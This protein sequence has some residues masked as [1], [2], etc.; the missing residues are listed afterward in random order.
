MSEMAE[1][2]TVDS[3]STGE[4]A[5]DH[6]SGASSGTDT[7][8]SPEFS[9]S[10][11]ERIQRLVAERNEARAGRE[12]AQHKA[13]GWYQHAMAAQHNQPK[14][15]APAPADGASKEEDPRERWIR[16]QLGRDEAGEKAYQTMEEMFRVKLAGTA[17]KE[18]ILREVDQLVNSRMQS[19]TGSFQLASEIDK[20]VAKG[21][22]DRTS[23]EEISAEIAQVVSH[24][25]QWAQQKGGLEVLLNNAYARRVREGKIKPYAKKPD[26]GVATLVGPGRT[27]GGAGNK[28][29]SQAELKS[30]AGR[31]R[32]LRGKD[33]KELERLDSEGPRDSGSGGK[34]SLSEMVKGGVQ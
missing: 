1:D 31:F 17:S 21:E 16:D 6:A 33:V 7:L 13:Q 9:E 14:P 5:A 26:N 32:S 24:Q 2:V 28:E 15:E 20:M 4:Q 10:A 29:T 18:D 34:M 27:G 12:E 11:N 30:I 3:S 25:P 22:M 23:G 8:T 19:V